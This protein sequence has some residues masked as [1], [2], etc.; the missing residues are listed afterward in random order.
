[1]PY[2][3]LCQAKGGPLLAFLAH[4]A[5][6]LNLFNIAA[7]YLFMISITQA[8]K[9]VVYRRKFVFIVP[10][11]ERGAIAQFI[12]RYYHNHIGSR[13]LKKIL[14]TFGIDASK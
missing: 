4:C 9:L 8:I 1:M 10:G 2:S 14:I 6:R 13:R 11:R 12:A 3:N 7:R 5:S